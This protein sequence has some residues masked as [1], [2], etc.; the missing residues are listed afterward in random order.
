VEGCTCVFGGNVKVRG[1]I[2]RND[3]GEAFRVKLDGACYEVSIACGDVMGMS[4]AGDAPLFFQSEES[5]RDRRK[6]DAES[7]G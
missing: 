2:G 5:P 6:G 3:E 7:F 4:Y 1:S